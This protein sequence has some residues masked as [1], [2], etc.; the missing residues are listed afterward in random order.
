MTDSQKKPTDFD[1]LMENYSPEELKLIMRESIEKQPGF[2]NFIKKVKQ[3]KL[4]NASFEELADLAK[5]NSQD[6]N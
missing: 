5:E 3:T 2:Q 4:E 1:L 6:E